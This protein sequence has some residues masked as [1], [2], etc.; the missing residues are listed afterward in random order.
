MGFGEVIGNQSV[1]WRIVHEDYDE[2]KGAKRKTPLASKDGTPERNNLTLG[3]FH[4]KGTDSV[5]FAQIGKGKDDKGSPKAHPGV[6]RVRARYKTLAEAQAAALWAYQ[7][8]AKED[9]MF[10][11]LIDVAAI[12]RKAGEVDPPVPVAEVRIDW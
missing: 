12:E 2:P 1:H 11:V 6:F 8:V 9:G 4:A 3:E 10:V 7:N 5:P